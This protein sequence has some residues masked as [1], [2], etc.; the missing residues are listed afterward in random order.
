MAVELKASISPVEEGT[1][2]VAE[3]E[4]RMLVLGGTML[5]D[6]AL[7]MLSVFDGDAVADALAKTASRLASSVSCSCRRSS[8]ALRNS[9]TSCG[10]SDKPS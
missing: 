2:V 9:N 10:R 4:T 8:I 1:S 6:V 3:L 7:A 5:V